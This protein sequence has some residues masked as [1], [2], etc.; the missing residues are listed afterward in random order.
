VIDGLGH[1]PEAAA[2]ARAAVAVLQAD[3][4]LG[5]NQALDRCHR[6][7]AGTRG[8][9]ISIAAIDLPSSQL[10]YAGI[11]N[12][13]GELWHE[14]NQQ[15]LVA[16]RG[17]VGVTSRTAREFS[18]E[19]RDGWVLVMHTDGIS[20]RFDLG[21]LRTDEQENA[22]AI[23]DAVLHRWGRESDDA[24]VV[25]ACSSAPGRRCRPAG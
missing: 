5:P 23:S 3:P 4:S 22:Q 6:A 15:H 1:G 21:A 20:R 18:F 12:V 7:L 19:L 9:A 14:G 11:G 8:A 13:E 17:I 24:T 2:A 25:I 10:R 16:Y